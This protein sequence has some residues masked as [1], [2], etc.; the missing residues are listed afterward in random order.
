MTI[1]EYFYSF[2]WPRLE[3]R[4]RDFNRV[5]QSRDPDPKFCNPESRPEFALKSQIPS[6]K[7]DAVIKRL[8]F[9]SDGV[10]VGVGVVSVVVR[11]LMTY[12]KSR[13]NIFSCENLWIGAVSGA[14]SATESESEESSLTFP[15]WSSDNQIV[16]VG[17][18][19]GRKNHSQCTFSCFVKGL[20]LPL[21]L[22]NSMTCC[23]F[24][25]IVNDEVE[26]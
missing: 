19:S 1:K 16:G 15:L 17:R 6:F 13:E 18:R 2:K 21:L 24:Q 5:L 9:T 22:E 20:V 10:G 4:R 23:S 26:S 12:W 8:V 25:L 11:A 14:I 3:L 7:Y